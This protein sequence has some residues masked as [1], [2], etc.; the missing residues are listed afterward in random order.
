MTIFMERSQTDPVIEADTASRGGRT[1]ST[2]AGMSRFWSWKVLSGVL[3]V[4]LVVFVI[5]ATVP[6][7]SVQQTGIEWHGLTSTSQ[8]YIIDSGKLTPTPSQCGSG[9]PS[10]CSNVWV[11]FNWSTHNGKAMTFGFLGVGSIGPG[12]GYTVLYSSTNLS[13]GG[14]SFYCGEPPRGCGNSFGIN[15]NDTSGQAWNFDWEMV[16]NYTTTVPL[17]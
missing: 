8:N 15:T 14:Y 6:V 7:R 4:G 16:Y 11:A 9:A 3:A 12:P 10:A 17:I 1:S 13:F 5:L 2:L